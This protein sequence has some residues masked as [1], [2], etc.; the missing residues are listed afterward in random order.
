MAPHLRRSPAKASLSASCARTP[1]RSITRPWSGGLTP[2]RPFVGNALWVVDITDPDGYRL[3][4]ESPT[5]MPEETEYEK[6]MG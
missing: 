3:E 4:F 5:D 2:R 1:W 6:G